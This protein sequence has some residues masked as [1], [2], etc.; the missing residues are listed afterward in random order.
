[1]Y[2]AGEDLIMKIYCVRYF[3]YLFYSMLQINVY[4]LSIKTA[5]RA[6]KTLAWQSKIV[7]DIFNSCVSSPSCNCNLMHP[8]LP[9]V[10]GKHTEITTV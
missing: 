3:L 7:S 9:S 5:C 4:I 6:V 8:D 1:M 10:T 2:F